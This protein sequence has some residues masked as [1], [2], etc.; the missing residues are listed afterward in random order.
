MKYVNKALFLLILFTGT[1]GIVHAQQVDRG[2]LQKNLAPITFYN[3]EGPQ[4]RIETRE[5]IRQ[6]GAVL[7]QA[8]KARQTRTGTNNR[9]FVIHSVT[10]ADGDKLDADIFGLGSNAG[11]DHIR[12]LRTIIQGY[13]QESY[14]YTASDAALIAEYVTIYNAVYRGNWN[15][16]SG[17]F[18]KP[19]I[20][21]LN[22]DSAGLAVRYQEWPGRTL[23]LIPLNAGGLS[24]INTSAISDSRVVERLQTEDN[25]GIPQRQGMVD[26]KEREA[27]QAR[28]DAAN[29]REAAKAE[30]AAIARDRQT[31]NEQQRQ[32]ERDRQQLEQDK[33][34][35]KVSGEEAAKRDEELARREAEASKKSDELDQR[36]KDL[37]AQRQDAANQEQFAQ[38]KQ[39]EARQ[40]REGIARDQ[41]TML[42]QGIPPQGSIQGI[43]CLLLERPDATSGRL[44]SLDPATGKEL[45]RSAL[46]TV[47][48]RTLTIIDNKVL[49]I[50]GENKGN[51]AVRLIEIDPRSLEMVSQGND[52]LHPGSLLWVN[53]DDMYAI[54]AN[55]DGTFNLGRFNTDMTLQA[56]SKITIHPN[57]MLSMQ[58][59]LIL[60]QRT[61]GTP[62]LLNPRDLTEKQ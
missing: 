55:R 57:A 49:A 30:E 60:T 61:N 39:D 14:G 6:I 59:G 54:T 5:Q 58:Q 28:E 56:K 50:A 41:Q 10:A 44:V 1:A 25:K 18:K 12:N 19:V 48:V 33:A 34:S 62:A 11:V 4:A 35:G 27:A 46:N 52:D 8:V 42:E 53:D 2:E 26:L 15:Y 3:N 37:A 13:L 32:A 17:R 7:G 40:D 51:S 16:F 24:S 23:M 22:R 31:L 45:K 47:Y 29:K 43:I 20:D 21:N 9:Y 36:D 38:Q